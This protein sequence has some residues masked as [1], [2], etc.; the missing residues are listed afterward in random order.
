MCVVPPIAGRNR[1]RR[2]LLFKECIAIII[3]KKKKGLDNFLEL[4]FLGFGVLSWSTSLFCIVG[5][6]PGAGS[7]AVAVLL[8]LVTG[9]RRQV[10]FDT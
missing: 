1:E 4:I 8:A 10:I 5:E 6:L 7:A 3:K 2:R 9:D